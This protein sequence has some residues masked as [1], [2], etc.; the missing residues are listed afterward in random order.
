MA[1]TQREVPSVNRLSLAVVVLAA[2]VTAAV[3]YWVHEPSCRT[4][5]RAMRGE[6]RHEIDGRL[7]Y[8]DGRCW[9]STPMPPMDTP[10]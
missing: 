10:L 4:D 7:L 8:F 5:A 6:V 1:M 3:F 2:L 9:S